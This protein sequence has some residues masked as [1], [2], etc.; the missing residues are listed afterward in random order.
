M[1]RNRSTVCTGEPFLW[2]PFID[3]H[4]T[5][6]IYE[7][8]CPFLFAVGSCTFTLFIL[9]APDHQTILFNHGVVQ[10]IAHLLTSVSYKVSY[11]F[12]LWELDRMSMD[13]VTALCICFGGQFSYIYNLYKEKSLLGSMPGLPKTLVPA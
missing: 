10:N 11:Y 13:I 5:N 2:K 6:G 7:Y 4:K 12:S 1:D 8:L 9:Q 3:G